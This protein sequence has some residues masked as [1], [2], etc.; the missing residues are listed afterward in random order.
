[1]TNSVNVSKAN[2]AAQNQVQEIRA[3]GKVLE[4]CN[5][6][7]M[8]YLLRLHCESFAPARAGQFVNLSIP[9]FFL[10]RPLAIAD[11][12]RYVDGSADLTVIVARVGGGTRALGGLPVGTEISV[13]GPLG[14]GFDLNGF[15]LTGADADFAAQPVLIGG[16]SGIPPLYYLAKEFVKIGAAPQVYLG[17]RNMEAVY[18][19]KEFGEIGCAVT[20]ATEDGSYG[21]PGFV[22]S[23]LPGEVRNVYA[24][25]PGGMLQAVKS[26]AALQKNGDFEN[27]KPQIQLSLEAHMGCGFGACLGCTVRTVRGLERVCLEGPVFNCED[28]I[29]AD[30]EAAA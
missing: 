14:N 17:F 27:G 21:R 16:G 26:W 23:A 12:H 25:G 4:I 29:F 11:L 13:L 20:I 9:G 30:G 22:T 24:C 18:F 19:E 3:R 10:R 2:I 1:M 6:T 15:D 7:D 28:V 8:I 5:L